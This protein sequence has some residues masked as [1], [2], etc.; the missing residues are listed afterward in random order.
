MLLKTL[1][2]ENECK[3]YRKIRKTKVKIKRNKEKRK[4]N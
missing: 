3:K 1:N 2:I 4:E